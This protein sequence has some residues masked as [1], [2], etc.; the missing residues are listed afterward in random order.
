MAFES[1]EASYIGDQL[2]ANVGRMV[3]NMRDNAN[4][5]KANI[6]AGRDATATGVIMKA[7]ANLFLARMQWVVDLATRNNT[8]YQAALA[9]NGWLAADVNS[10]RTTL[11]GVCNHTVAA[12]LTT[13]AQVNTEADFILANVP[14]FERTF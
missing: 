9:S 11:A 2:K 6:T 4:G 10:L 1:I 12:T 8:K 3:N 14:I 7:D 13:G 5:Y